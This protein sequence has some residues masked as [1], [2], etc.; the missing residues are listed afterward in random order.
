MSI[1][2]RQIICA[3]I[4]AI[5]SSAASEPTLMSADQLHT[6]EIVDSLAHHPAH[7]KTVNGQVV[8][9]DEFHAHAIKHVGPD[10]HEDLQHIHTTHMTGDDL[11]AA[12]AA[13]DPD[14]ELF[15]DDDDDQLNPAAVRRQLRE[16]GV[17]ESN[18]ERLTQEIMLAHKQERVQS[19]RTHHGSNETGTD[20]MA[21]FQ[22]M[23]PMSVLKTEFRKI[24]ADTD[25]R[26]F[27]TEVKAHFE[28]QLNELEHATV[29]KMLHDSHYSHDTS[30]ENIKK[31]HDELKAHYEEQLAGID[32]VW[33]GSDINKD[34]YISFPEYERF[35]QEAHWLAHQEAAAK[36]LLG[37][38]MHLFD[39]NWREEL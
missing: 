25:G 27:V 14:D 29:H 11:K 15:T 12:L 24:D 4:M 2:L 23:V 6:K 30:D 9:D 10:Y 21:G 31:V 39:E 17:R 22:P 20:R 33:V 34:G 35:V 38:D 37:E 7:V 32:T 16:Q 28:K 36:K 8:T 5:V 3:S 26:V 1:P 18:L 13:K 19:H